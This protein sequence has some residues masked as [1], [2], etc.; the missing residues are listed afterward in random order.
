MGIKLTLTLPL[1]AI[2]M[3][4][5]ASGGTYVK[6]H[7]GDDV[8]R[9]QLGLLKPVTFVRILS[10]DGDSKKT[11]SVEGFLGRKD[12]EIGLKPGVHQVL[13][14]YESVAFKSANPVSL[15]FRVEA[16]RKYLVKTNAIEKSWKPTIVDVTSRPECWGVNAEISFRSDCDWSR[17]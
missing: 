4:A 11:F 13:I 9:E 6:A 2:L 15:T 12:Y 3:S 10:I 1:F 7:S 17:P 5:C 8:P 16:G 14:A